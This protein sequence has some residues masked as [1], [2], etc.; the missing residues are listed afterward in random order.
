MIPNPKDYKPKYSLADHHDRIG[1]LHKQNIK[2]YPEL[3]REGGIP[4]SNSKD[5]FYAEKGG[6]L[7]FSR[8]I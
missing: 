1:N 2:K 3:Y 8:D 4:K 5:S 6:V 7:I